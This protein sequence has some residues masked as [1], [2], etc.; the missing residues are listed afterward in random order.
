MLSIGITFPPCRMGP[1]VRFTTY[2]A[3]E[4]QRCSTQRYGLCP[5][6]LAKPKSWLAM[7]VVLQ[8]R[9]QATLRS[10]TSSVSEP[11]DVGCGDSRDGAIVGVGR[12]GARR[13]RLPPPS[14]GGGA[15]QQGPDLVAPEL[16][17]TMVAR[18][19]RWLHGRTT[20]TCN[21]SAAVGEGRIRL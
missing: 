6:G 1:L 12:H 20:P 18:M 11:V 8:L 3:Y 17:T 13:T 7:E 14:S 21:S 9:W 10:S 5:C 19:A 16:V 4:S 2:R 15:R